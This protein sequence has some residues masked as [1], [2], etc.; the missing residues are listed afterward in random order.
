MDAIRDLQFRLLS[1]LNSTSREPERT[2]LLAVSNNASRSS[3]AEPSPPVGRADPLQP[4]SVSAEQGRHLVELLRHGSR[5]LDPD[6]AMYTRGPSERTTGQDVLG[7][8]YDARRRLL[9]EVVQGER[10]AADADADATAASVGAASSA[11][12]ASG[13]SVWPAITGCRTRRQLLKTLLGASPGLVIAATP[14]ARASKRLL[15]EK[16]PVLFNLGVRTLYLQPLQHD[17]HQDDLDQ[18]QTTGTLPEALGKFLDEQ[19]GWQMTDRD[20]NATY[21]EV[22]E[23]ARRAGL[24][25]VALDLLASAHLRGVEVGVGT[26][27]SNVETRA[28][29]ASHVAAKRIQHDQSQQSSTQGPGRWVA[30]VDNLHAGAFNGTRG[31]ADR[32]GVLSLRVEDVN[33]PDAPRLEAGVDPGLIVPPSALRAHGKLRCDYLLK[34]RSPT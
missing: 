4:F 22:V 2:A 12:T 32:L 28:R 7:A 5:A 6:Y 29:V 16:M 3:I 33:D 26:L 30:L 20:A 14:S 9:Q 10:A 31:I 13:R 25:M 24:R 8:F 23:A 11:A 19:D 1:R 17:V 34:V 18:L 15:I 27:V 21:R